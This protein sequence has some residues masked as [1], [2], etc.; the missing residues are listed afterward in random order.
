M[1]IVV[2]FN[3]IEGCITS[4][5]VLAHTFVPEAPVGPVDPEA[6]VGPVDPVGPVA[7]VAPVG[8]VGPDAPLPDPDPTGDPFTK[9]PDA[10]VYVSVPEPPSVTEFKLTSTIQSAVPRGPTID[11]TDPTAGNDPSE[12]CADHDRLRMLCKSSDFVLNVGIDLYRGHRLSRATVSAALTKE[13]ANID[14][15]STGGT[16]APRRLPDRL[17]PIHFL[18]TGLSPSHALCH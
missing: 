9:R 1:V 18:Q 16:G 8:P 11:S 14:S 17:P 10:S 13:H 4:I 12:F 7:P 2:A 3:G 15:T 6:P 5:N